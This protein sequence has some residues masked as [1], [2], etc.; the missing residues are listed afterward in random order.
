MAHTKFRG[1]SVSADFLTFVVYEVVWQEAQALQVRGCS[2]RQRHDLSHSFVKALV[3]AVPEQ[4]RQFS[5]GH[6]IL[7]MPHLVVH[8]QEVIH[9]D[10]GAHFDPGNVTEK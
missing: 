1:H 6:L 9:G 7:V 10:F 2:S 3:G 8:S 5:V 4:I